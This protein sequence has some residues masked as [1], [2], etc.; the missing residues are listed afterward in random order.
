MLR[1]VSGHSGKKG[2]M[3]RESAAFLGLVQGERSGR[4]PP[5][6]PAGKRA[7]PASAAH[8]AAGPAARTAPLQALKTEKSCLLDCE[9]GMVNIAGGRNDQAIFGFFSQNDDCPA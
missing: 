3:H 7:S 2:P 5:A 1:L 9:Y 6:V 8:S 4:R